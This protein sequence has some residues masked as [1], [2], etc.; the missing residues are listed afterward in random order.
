MKKLS[1]V[2]LLLAITMQAMPQGAEK[3]SREKAFQTAKAFVENNSR[4]PKAEI[5]LVSESN[6]FVFDIGTQGFV[7]VSGNT[8][9]PPI[10]GYSFDNPMPSLEDAPENFRSW[11]AHYGEMIDFA[12]ENGIQPEAKVLKLWDDAKDGLFQ[13]KNTTTVDPLTTTHWDQNCYYNEYCPST[14]SWWNCGHVYAGC[15][16]CAMAQVMKYWNHP[17]VGSGSHSYVHG[18]YGMQSADFGATTY[19][20]SEMPEQIYDHNDAIATLMYHCGVSVNMNYGADGSGAYSKDVETALRSYFG[21]CGAKY[22][23]KSKYDDETWIAMLKADLDLSHPVYYSGNSG[24]GG[25]AFVCDGYDAYDNFHFNFGWSGSGDNYYSVY[26]VNGYNQQQ[27]AVMN[28]IPLDIRADENGIIYVSADGEGNGSSWA[29]ATSKLEYAT[30]LSNDGSTKIWVKRGTYYGDDT[31]PINAFSITASDRVYGGFNG[32]EG[33]DF[34]LSDRDLVNN[35]AILDGGGIKRVLNQP[36]FLN[37][38][39]RAVWDGFIIQNG[40]SGSGAGVFLN[41]YTTLS[42]CVIRNNVSSG[43]GGGVYINSATGTSQTALNNCE[44]IGNTASLGGG[45]CDRNSSVITN[46]KI[47]NNTATTKGGGIYLYN[48][49]KPTFRGCLVSNNTAVLGGGIYAR[50]KCTMTNC[51]IVMNQA[52]E[53]YGGVFNENRY[54]T[55]TSCILWGNEANGTASQ[56]Y[57]DCKFEYCAV[58]GGITGEENID[59]PAE[60]DGEE[61]GVYIR[62]ANPAQGTGIEYTEADWSIASRSIC[63][64]AGKPGSPGFSFDI[65]GDP[66]LQHSRVDIGA[67]ERNASL[68]LIEDHLTPSGTYNFNGTILHEPGYYTAVFPMPDCDSVVGL[69]LLT[70]MGMDEITSEAEILSVEVFTILGQPVGTVKSIE[71]VKELPLKKGC[72]LLMIKTSEGSMGKKIVLQ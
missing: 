42:N 36:E 8:V 44:I 57:G 31:D 40:N 71:A 39:S 1:L 64:N 68:T 24:K 69:T 51:D 37:A 28:I 6:V 22:R 20:W 66:R 11:I 46:C 33:P 49:D 55:F 17:E 72:Y 41:D 7:M 9:L 62:F 38:G 35:A 48:T 47:S 29:N 23:E 52:T 13:A 30:Y 16:A 14:G 63:L 65:A 54:S 32:D 27:A 58:Q 21:Y 19:H 26:D 45:L 34:N 12:N 56:N 50:G 5:K 53:S 15:V 67:Y 25:H 18:T 10:L 61:P 2:I 4:A 59:L 70:P 3:I 43:I 60:N